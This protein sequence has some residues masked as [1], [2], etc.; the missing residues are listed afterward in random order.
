[1]FKKIRKRIMLQNMMMVSLVVLV[2]FATIFIT[3]YSRVQNENQTKLMYDSPMLTHM[4]TFSL[5]DDYSEQN[6]F[7]VRRYASEIWEELGNENS[8]SSW[9]VNV[10]REE[11]AGILTTSPRRISPMAGMSFS[12]LVDENTNVLEIDSIIDFSQEA[13]QQ[14]TQI[15]MNDPRNVSTVTFEGR[16]WQFMVSPVDVT[17]RTFVYTSPES[18]MNIVSGT[19]RA[20]IVSGDSNVPGDY[21][22]IRFVDVTESYQMLQ[23]LALTLTGAA[24]VVLAVVFFISRYFSRLAVKPMEEAWDKQ[25]RFITDASHELKTPLSVIN[26]NCGVLYAN[27]DEQV[28]GQ[29]KWVDSISR[30]T[31]R[32]SGLV[33]SLLSLASMEDA[34]LTMHSS[35]FDFSED[36]T[37][38]LS[39]IEIIANEKDIK[40]KKEIEPD[41]A[42]ESDREQV[43]KVLFTLLDNAVK[44]TPESGEI[45]VT[46]T[47]EKRHIVCT[48]RNSGDGIPP[49]DLP[50]VFDRFYRG[51]PARS[52]D[53]SGYGLGLAIAKAIADRLKITITAG[54]KEGEYTE[55]ILTIPNKP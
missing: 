46:L 18:I 42:I 3:S 13:F 39:E 19:G 25:R 6:E 28:E 41:I 23:T 14:V 2:V 29:I 35:T 12:V 4:T 40:I 7:G 55:F 45:T 9:E 5:Y 15:V 17:Q 10:Q 31:D 52:S 21:S 1:M 27:K 44:Y 34:E 8:S 32:M 37:A 54:S 53:N 22:Y 48:V 38:A 47:K 36:M 33:S 24:L 43:Q 50:N 11:Q 51:D 20:F 49:E 26:A 16:R 30:A